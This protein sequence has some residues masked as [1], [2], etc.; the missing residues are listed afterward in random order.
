MIEGIPGSGIVSTSPIAIRPEVLLQIIQAIAPA[1]SALITFSSIR[2]DRPA[3]PTV[4][5]NAHLL[6]VTLLIL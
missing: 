5:S 6:D 4:V 1:A 2:L 3:M